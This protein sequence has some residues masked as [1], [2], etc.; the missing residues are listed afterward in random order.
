MLRKKRQLKNDLVLKAASS[1][2]PEIIFNNFYIFSK[3]SFAIQNETKTLTVP[4]SPIQS[5]LNSI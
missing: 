2:F 4:K 5:Y 3:M 1:A